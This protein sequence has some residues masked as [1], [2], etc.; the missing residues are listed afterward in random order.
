MLAL[1]NMAMCDGGIAVWDAKNHFDTWRPI[2]AIHAA[3]SD[4]NPATS[5]DPNCSH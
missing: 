3:A 4:G 2:T 1:V 5:P